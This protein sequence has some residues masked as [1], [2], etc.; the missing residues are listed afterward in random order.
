MYRNYTSDHA[1]VV[2]AA[3]E[4]RIL[5]AY[6]T[7]HLPKDPNAAVLD[8]GCGQGTTVR[9]CQ[10]LGWPMA[11]GVDISPEQ[12]QVAHDAGI[13]GVEHGDFLPY[14]QVRPKTFAAVLATDILEHMTK[15][16]VLEALDAIL[17]SLVKGGVFIARVPNSASPFAGRIVHG[18]F[19]HETA[20]TARSLVQI[21]KVVG[22]DQVD[23]LDTRPVK[24]GA[25]ALVRRLI[26]AVVAAAMR[27]S[28]AAETGQPTGHHVGQ[29]IVLVARK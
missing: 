4:R 26:W 7:P 9:A 12:V 3:A 29:T 19:T 23:V 11:K 17:A 20:F 2:D 25:K 10:Q 24:N 27:L 14:L 18:D 6:V 5:E 16:E 28:L 15:P 21:A 22:F 8:I 1:G 13:E